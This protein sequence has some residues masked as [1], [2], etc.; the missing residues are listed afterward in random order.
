MRIHSGEKPYACVFPGCFK[1]FSQSSNLSAHEKTHELM[2]K[3][4][5]MEEI[6]NKPIFSENPLKY[7][8][9]NPYSGTET[10]QKRRSYDTGR[11]TTAE[12]AHRPAYSRGAQAAW[13]DAAGSC[14]PYGY[15]AEPYCKDRKRNVQRRLRHIA[16]DSRCHGHEDRPDLI[17]QW[18]AVP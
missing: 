14:K 1:R 4:G 2:K 18:R 8:I 3:E 15:K 6:N 12:E 9:E 7:I 16:S 10:I 17:S 13:N 11:T 5:G